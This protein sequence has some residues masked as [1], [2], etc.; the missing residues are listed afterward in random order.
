MDETDIDI[1]DQYPKGMRAYMGK[2][3]FGYVI[4]VCPG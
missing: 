4:T 1:G 3:H 2:M